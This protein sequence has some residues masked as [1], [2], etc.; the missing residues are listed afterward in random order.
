MTNSSPR[1]DT[2]ISLLPNSN[3]VNSPESNRLQY[4]T[5]QVA[6]GC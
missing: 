5:D 6:F 1:L 3:V 2:E 4:G